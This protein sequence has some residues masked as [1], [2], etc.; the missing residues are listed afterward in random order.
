MKINFK[1]CVLF[2]TVVYSLLFV[3]CKLA[4]DEFPPYVVSKPVCLIEQKIGYF[5]FVG[6]EFD[7]FNSG[8]KNISNFYISFMVYDADTQ[9]NPFAGSNVIKM[10]FDGLV[11]RQETQKFFVDLD[12][13]VYTV[14][15]K[16]YLIDFFCI[17]KI[18]YE[19]GSTWED[20]AGVYYTNS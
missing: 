9:K 11:K 20:T 2:P 17:T 10:S 14:P 1:N 7:L 16:A 12:S 15:A 19:D 13:Y 5:N 4:Q 3:S 6:I 8:D 18:V